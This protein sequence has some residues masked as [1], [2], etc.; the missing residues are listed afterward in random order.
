MLGDP[1]LL[2][3]M[4]WTCSFCSCWG[5]R[6]D[7]RWNEVRTPAEMMMMAMKMIAAKII[8]RLWLD[9]VHHFFDLS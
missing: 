9:D 1:L 7:V 2:L 8:R 4:R 6:R 5:V 3:P